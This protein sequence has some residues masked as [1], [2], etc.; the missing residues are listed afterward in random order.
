MRQLD[1]G[2]KEKLR[3]LT[4]E[5]VLALRR[6]YLMKFGSAVS[7]QHWDTMQ[8]RFRAST[9]TAEG[10]EEWLTLMRQGLRLDAPRH[11]QPDPK[12]PDREA[13][14]ECR[15]LNDLVHAVRE[16]DGVEEWLELLEREWGHIFALA[17]ATAAER[18]EEANAAAGE[19]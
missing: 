11:P 18:K 4:M 5:V 9:R 7:K 6:A 8:A 16:L 3:T 10:P 1:E 12:R 14:S 17:R 13:N 19:D 15:A 2:T